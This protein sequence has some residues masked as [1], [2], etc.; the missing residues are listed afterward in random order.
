MGHE[1]PIP[2]ANGRLMSSTCSI[3]QTR[4]E[5]HL[6][7]SESVQLVRSEQQPESWA[8]ISHDDRLHKTRES[9]ME[10]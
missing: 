4:E 3:P 10:M 1:Q 8:Q 7:R 5:V 6:G 2:R 9:W